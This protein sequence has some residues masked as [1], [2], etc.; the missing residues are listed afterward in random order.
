MTTFN[1][2]NQK[3]SGNQLNAGRDININS[4]TTVHG[5][6]VIADSIRES[7]NKVASAEMPDELR[8][9]LKSL[10]HAV[11]SM[12][13][14]LS[15]E[16]AQQATQHLETLVEE[17]TSKT[18]RREWWHVSVEGLK[19]AASNIGAVGKPVLELVA[20]IIPLLK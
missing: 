5:D 7:F 10:T 8:E 20:R 3:I 1:Q 15:K 6:F 18:P 9:L 4:G 11:K 16:E 2:Q 19:K 12:N 17:A 14:A 13:E